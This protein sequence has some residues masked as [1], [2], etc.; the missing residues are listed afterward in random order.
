[1]ADLDPGGKVNTGWAVVAVA[2]EIVSIR[3]LNADLTVKETVY[4]AN[5]PTG[6]EFSGTTVLMGELKDA[7]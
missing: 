3:I 7:A 5:V 6:K 4:E 2:G 1:M